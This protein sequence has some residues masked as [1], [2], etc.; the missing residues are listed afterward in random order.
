M[1]KINIDTLDRKDLLK[2]IADVQYVIDGMWSDGYGIHRDTGIDLD[3]C[4]R[5]HDAI[6][7][8]CSIDTKA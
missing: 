2:L 7:T 4:D 6:G 8:F 3:T 1:A 5:L